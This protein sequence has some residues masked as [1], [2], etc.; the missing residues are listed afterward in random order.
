MLQ[1][2]TQTKTMTD[3]LIKDRPLFGLS[4]LIRE[5]EYFVLE[6]FLNVSSHLLLQFRTPVTC[7]ASLAA[8][9]LLICDITIMEHAN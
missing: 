1:V 7:F 9:S 5:T 6:H 4:L 2:G 3:P 8:F